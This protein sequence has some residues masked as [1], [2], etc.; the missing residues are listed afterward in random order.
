MIPNLAAIV[1]LYIMYRMAEPLWLT[2]SHYRS[3]ATRITA[4]A[5]GLVVLC[6]VALLLYEI[7]TAGAS[8]PSGI[9]P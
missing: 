7:M 3:E 6:L 5:L 9:I 4:V 2:P 1:S 8:V